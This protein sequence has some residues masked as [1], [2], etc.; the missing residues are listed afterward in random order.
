MIDELLLK[1]DASK[2]YFGVP[3]ERLQCLNEAAEFVQQI[4]DIENRFMAY[5]RRMKVAYE[6]SFPSGE[7]TDQ[8]NAKAQFYL[9]IRSIIYKQTK[10]TAP[11]AEVMNKVV[12][13]WLR[14]LYSLRG[15][16]M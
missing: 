4:K 7:L 13:V 2:F 1:F 3:L 16:K 9:A 11:D 8:E 6:I 14:K 12:E 10:G 15:L 5:S